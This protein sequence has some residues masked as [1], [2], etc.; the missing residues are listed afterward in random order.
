MSMA[1]NA[2]ALY[3]VPNGGNT[4]Q[5]L[6]KPAAH[7]GHKKQRY[8]TQSAHHDKARRVQKIHL[9]APRPLRSVRHPQLSEVQSYRPARH[10][11]TYDH[12]AI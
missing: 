4:T 6:V 2:M 9:G 3:G 10:I 1:I 12:T 11:V 7:D 8:C 5:R